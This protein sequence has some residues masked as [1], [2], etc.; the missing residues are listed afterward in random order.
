[1]PADLQKKHRDAGFVHVVGAL[2]MTSIP[3]PE[4]LRVVVA[5]A[6]AEDI[7]T[8]DATAALVPADARATATVIARE[9][10]VVCGIPYFNETM[11]QID[12]ATEVRWHV[13]E[14]RRVD[15]ETKLCSVSGHARS[16]LTA[17][18]VSVNFVQTLSSTAT[19]T[20]R[21]V[22]AIADVA[23]ARAKPPSPNSGRG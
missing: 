3:V 4:N 20:R 22:E 18:R 21:Y 8:G 23:G 19:A 17:E 16:L 15:A 1:M 5:N 14:G 7:G 12:P 9:Q 10:C 13:E 11:R 2:K 6:L